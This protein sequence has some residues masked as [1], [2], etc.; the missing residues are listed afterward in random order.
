MRREIITQ[1]QIIAYTREAMRGFYSRSI[2]HL[3][4]HL[5]EDFVWIGAFDFQLTTSKQQFLEVIQAEL[6]SVPFTIYD[7]Q[8]DVISRDRDTFV[9][10]C[11][12]K[13][14]ADLPDN[15]SMQTHT[16]LTVV[17]RYV[18]G[19]PKLIHVHGSNAQDIPLTTPKKTTP[20]H[21]G[22]NDFVR[23]LQESIPQISPNIMFRATTGKH[24]IVSEADILYVQAQGQHS[25]VHTK[26]DSIV[27]SGIL[28][29]HQA[30]LS[31]S[32]HRIHK[33]YLIN[34]AY[35]TT[36]CRYQITL[37]NQ[38]ALPVSKDRYLSLK[39]LFKG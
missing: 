31:S 9:L 34:L 13:L 36:L 4:H 32:F 25:V 18:E 22:S 1:A 2:D 10:Y 30:Q 38:V 35:L 33:S 23:Y 28:R 27:V 6:S 39:Q 3:V 17:W 5:H 26:T 21:Q 11:T 7:E 24:V 16:R 29:T 12:F 19:V 15:G 8:Y 20:A 14:Q 37:D